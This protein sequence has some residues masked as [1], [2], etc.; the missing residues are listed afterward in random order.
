MPQSVPAWKAELVLLG[1]T[2]IWAGTFVVV[3]GVIAHIS[4][5]LFTG[6]RF[7][8]ATI[9]L[10]ILWHGSFH[11]WEATALRHGGIL[12][13]L[14]AGGFLL[15]TAG[16]LYTT[17]SRSAFITGTTLALVPGF[18]LL[19]QRRRISGWEWLGA[20]VTLIGLWQL[21]APNLKG[22]NLG[23]ALT[24]LST[25]FWGLYI[26][27]L[28]SFTRS[29]SSSLGYSL[30]LTFVQLAVT[31]L[32][33]FAAYGIAAAAGSPS[34][35]LQPDWSFFPALLLAL[36]YTAFLASLTAMLLQTHYQRYTTPFRATLIYA[37]E[38]L[39]ASVI[40]WIALSE[41]FTVRE[42]FGAAL[43]LVGT[44]LAQLPRVRY[45][46]AQR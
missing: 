12:G 18:Q 23:D 36:A 21:T 8:V 15:Q 9:G 27:A 4:P 39:I 34:F 30:R 3:K 41:H 44:G 2:F 11:R 17:A 33:G 19:F 40:A 31:A 6:L 7:L 35:P 42:L 26:V 20:G 1:I 22:W 32:A 29:G 16:L 28:D 43:I 24:I 46:T 38:P 45:V 5:F 13:I 10:L 25:L 37:L 14:L